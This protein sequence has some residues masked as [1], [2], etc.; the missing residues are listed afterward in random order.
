M[1]TNFYLERGVC[2]HCNQAR[3]EWHIGKSSA[4]WAFSLHIMPE[5]GINDLADWVQAWSQPDTRIKDEYGTELTPHE[6]MCCITLRG[7]EPITS[8]PGYNSWDEFHQK[9]FSIMGLGNL[10]YPEVD[11]YQCVGH[12]MGTWALLVGE[13]S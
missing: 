9:N 3:G 2:P 8:P 11:G 13:F 6:M 12:G 7:R 10:L 5:H 1:G 4:G